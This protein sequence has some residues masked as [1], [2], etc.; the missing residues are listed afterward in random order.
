VRQDA[1][2]M[3]QDQELETFV[4]PFSPSPPQ[5]GNLGLTVELG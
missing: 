2:M 3:G 1:I 4:S 5:T